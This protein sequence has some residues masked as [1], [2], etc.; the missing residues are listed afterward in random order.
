MLNGEYINVYR[1]K[2]YI[3]INDKTSVNIPLISN[4]PQVFYLDNEEGKINKKEFHYDNVSE[5]Y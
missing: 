5:V 2:L 3:P 1:E 4:N